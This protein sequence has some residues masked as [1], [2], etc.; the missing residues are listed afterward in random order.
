M[1]GDTC[2]YA[3]GH[4]G[5]PHLHRP[6]HD[7]VSERLGIGGMVSRTWRR[8]RA[9]SVVGYVAAESQ[10]VEGAY[11]EQSRHRFIFTSTEVEHG[12]LSI[13]NKHRISFIEAKHRI[14]SMV[15]L[16]VFSEPEYRI[17]L[18]SSNIAPSMRNDHTLRGIRIQTLYNQLSSHK[19]FRKSENMNSL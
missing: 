17:R 11:G 13:E 6:Y 10:G 2:I 5:N 14:A 1:G 12:I 8:S 15:Q 16:I 4:S 7:P 9:I 3:V 19:D 18:P